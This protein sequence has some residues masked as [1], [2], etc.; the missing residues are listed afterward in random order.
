M[1][2]FIKEIIGGMDPTVLLPELS[3]LFAQLD[4]VLRVLVL[5]GPLCLLGL[6]LLYL[7]APPAEANH[8]FGY[9][10][11]WG[12]S[13][14]ESW[15]FTQQIAGLV[16]TGLGL[17]LTIVMA[18]ICN[19]YR[20]MAVEAMVLSALTAVVVELVLVWLSTILINALVVFQFDRRGD[21]R[22]EGK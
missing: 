6:G 21:R 9:R 18:F 15:Q 1:V 14:V 19:G 5:V 11:F 20:D 10:H 4:S 16:W 13:S 22:K 8:S 7:L 17:V 12:M 3:T 2:D